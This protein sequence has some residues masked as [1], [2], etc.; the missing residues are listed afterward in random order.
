MIMEVDTSMTPLVGFAT[1]A[2]ICFQA[3][4]G[5]PSTN[6]RAVLRLHAE[7][8][9]KVATTYHSSISVLHAN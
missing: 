2:L 8:A 3:L 9:R 7:M 6:H 4:M 5:R 1:K